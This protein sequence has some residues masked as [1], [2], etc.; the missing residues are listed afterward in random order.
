MNPDLSLSPRRLMEICTGF[1]AFKAV[2]VANELE[3]FTLFEQ[4]GPLT[5]S[6]VANLLEIEERPTEMLLTANAALGLLD[7]RDHAF[8]NTPL[9]A[10]FLVKGKEFYFGR[11]IDHLD[12]RSYAGW[13]HLSEAVRTNRPATWDP[14]AQKTVFEGTDQGFTVTFQDAMHSLSRHSASTISKVLDLSMSHCLLDVGGGTGAY[15]IELAKRNPNLKVGIYDLP[16]V[17]SLATT[18]IYKSGLTGRVVTVPGD[19]FAEDLPGGYD[20]ILLSMILHDW[21]PQDC[22]SILRKCHRALPPGGRIIISE[23]LVDD[24]KS[25]PADAALMS[26]NMLVNTWGRNYTTAEYSQWLVESGFDA[27]QRIHV[28][29]ASANGLLVAIRSDPETGASAPA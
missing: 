16:P 25:G 18:K 2:A 8:C 28:D 10:N 5:V 6:A 21:S 13:A 23:L 17:C 4:H 26:L 12:R 27:P 7:V 9:A 19:F 15:A 24:N 1:W 20:T 29:T 14:A 22:Q 11:W 3:L